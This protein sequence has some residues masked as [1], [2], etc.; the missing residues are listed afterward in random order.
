MDKNRSRGHSNQNHHFQ[1]EGVVS[2]P[3]SFNNDHSGAER[4]PFTNNTNYSPRTAPEDVVGT[5]NIFRNQSPTHTPNSQ[6]VASIRTTNQKSIRKLSRGSQQP[7]HGNQSPPVPAAQPLEKNLGQQDLELVPVQIE[8]LE[9]CF[10]KLNEQN[11]K[12]QFLL[13]MK[14][15]ADKI[16]R[17]CSSVNTERSGEKLAKMNELIRGYQAHRARILESIAQKEGLPNFI[18]CSFN[19]QFNVS[20]G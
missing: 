11:N 19:Q 15:I 4:A 6:V 2:S 10:N 7:S 16:L 13:A 18:N 17:L 9:F 8:I 1:I 20:R 3:G 14:F 5:K 12:G